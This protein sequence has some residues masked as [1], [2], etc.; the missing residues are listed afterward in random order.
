MNGLSVYASASVV[1]LQVLSECLTWH[2]SSEAAGSG[3]RGGVLH[4]WYQ[5]GDRF[6]TETLTVS[7]VALHISKCIDMSLLLIG[8]WI[9]RHMM[10][11]GSRARLITSIR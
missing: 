4:L 11:R 10:P 5:N 2:F 3:F 9:H 8:S 6:L 7:G 1:S